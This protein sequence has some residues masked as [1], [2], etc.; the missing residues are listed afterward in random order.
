MW[1]R[2]EVWE[3][4]KVPTEEGM[5]LGDVQPECLVSSVWFLLASFSKT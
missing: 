4:G 2:T 3:V 5:L 1:L